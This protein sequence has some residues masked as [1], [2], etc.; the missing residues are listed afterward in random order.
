MKPE[1]NSKFDG[2]IDRITVNDKT[3]RLKCVI[4]EVYPMSCPKCGGRVELKY[5]HGKCEY[6]GTNYSTQFKLQE[7][8]D[9]P[10]NK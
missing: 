4:T 9:E 7:D 1:D 6:C 5:G 10:D 8:K 3:Y 2:Y